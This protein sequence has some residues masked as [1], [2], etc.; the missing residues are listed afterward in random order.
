MA[1]FE[2]KNSMQNLHRNVHVRVYIQSNLESEQQNTKAAAPDICA[3]A[4]RRHCSKIDPKNRELLQCT[5]VH[6]F[7]VFN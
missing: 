5:H 1:L 4:Q 3:G 2:E 7:I 6:F